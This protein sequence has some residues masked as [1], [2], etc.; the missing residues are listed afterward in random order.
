VSKSASRLVLLLTAL[1]LGVFLVWP[2]FESVLGAFIDPNGRFSSAYLTEVFRN[3]IY[4]EGLWNALL[5][6]V[7]STLIA[8]VISLPLAWVGD[9]YDFPGKPLL[10]ALVLAPMVLPPFVGAIG[11]I[12]VFGQMGAVNALLHSLGLLAPDRTIDW[13]GRARFPGIVLLNGLHLYPILYLNAA[14]ALANVDPV[15]KPPKT[16][17]ASASTSSSASRYLS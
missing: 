12:A 8:L 7:G 15:R 1:F 2:V 16:S 6:G 4:L 3:P 17:A 11:M 5:M 13:L 14:A 10:S 9:R